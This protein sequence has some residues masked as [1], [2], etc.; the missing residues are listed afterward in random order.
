MSFEYLRIQTQCL[1][2][3]WTS[4]RPRCWACTSKANVGSQ[5]RPDLW[6]PPH[7]EWISLGAFEQWYGI[8]LV[9][10]WANSFTFQHLFI[11]CSS[12]HNDSLLLLCFQLREILNLRTC[13]GPCRRKTSQIDKSQCNRPLM[14]TCL[15]RP[16]GQII[17]WTFASFQRFTFTCKQVMTSLITA[18]GLRFWKFWSVANS[19]IF[20][21]HLVQSSQWQCHLRCAPELAL[22]QA[23]RCKPLLLLQGDVWS[24]HPLLK[25]SRWTFLESH[26]G[27]FLDRPTSVQQLSQSSGYFAAPNIA[28]KRRRKD[29][30][31]SPH[32]SK[33]QWS[34]RPHTQSYSTLTF[35][36]R[37]W[38]AWLVGK[39][40]FLG[41]GP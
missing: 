33:R 31:E 20:Q 11:I 36:C 22:A 25:P 15:Q 10:N 2:N 37:R 21:P 27:K 38:M 28:L 4:T 5:V 23:Q 3:S 12:I 35:H 19:S 1:S 40:K 39:W 29:K 30:M 14:D 32:R 26:R 7:Q 9:W 13:H 34:S 8:S 6:E 41:D 16:G 18:M 17:W 24:S